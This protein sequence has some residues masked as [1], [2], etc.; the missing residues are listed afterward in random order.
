MIN[1][2]SFDIKSSHLGFNILSIL[3]GTLFENKIEKNFKTFHAII[4]ISEEDQEI[5]YLVGDFQE[6]KY[7]CFIVASPVRFNGLRVK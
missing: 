2:I 5:K 4:L 7:W 6:K 1:D 3:M